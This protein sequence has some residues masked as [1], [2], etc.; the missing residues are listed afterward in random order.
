MTRKQLQQLAKPELIEI[1]LRQQ[2]LIEQL[3]ARVA[4]LEEQIKRLTEPP[5]DASNSSIPPSQ[6]PK[7]NRANCQSKRGPKRG[8]PG[9]GRSRQQ[10]DVTVECRPHRWARCGADLTEV[11]AKLLGT[12][13]V[14]ELPAIQPLII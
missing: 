12:S 1:I 11:P 2:A 10:P 7:P 9:H 13:Q 8:H 14:V 5:K 6:S 4:E 3:Q